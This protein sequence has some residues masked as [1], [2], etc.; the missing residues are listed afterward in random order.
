MKVLVLSDIHGDVQ[1]F[2]AICDYEAADYVI[3]LGDSELSPTELSAVDTLIHGNAYLDVGRPLEVK[4]LNGL[5]IVMT[6]GH[7][8]HVQKSDER[9]IQLL[10]AHEAHLIMHGHTHVPRF[11]AHKNGYLFNPGAI[12]GPRGGH[13]ASYG[14]LTISK[15]RF[16]ITF[17]TLN[18]QEFKHEE[19]VFT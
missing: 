3:S 19:G 4:P 10:I 7:L 15:N 12:Y 8:E 18:H 14:V 17:K 11:M 16:I 6:H 2:N 1:T 13:P 9:L 5:K